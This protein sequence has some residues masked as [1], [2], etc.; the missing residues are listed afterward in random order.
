MT[1]T[2]LQ[3][4]NGI[5]AELAV[6][7]ISLAPIVELR[8]ALP[9]ALGVYKMPLLQAFPVVIIGNML[10]AFLIVYGWDWFIRQVGKY[11]PWLNRLLEKRYQRMQVQW[12]AK[13]EKYGP[14]ALILFVAIPLPGSG[15]W[16]GS[17][18]AWLFGI[19]KKKALWAI[20]AGALIS[21]IAV[22]VIT[23]GGLSL[24]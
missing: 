7:I 3:L 9:I 21:G 5:P 22:T 23:L 16:S 19:K 14:W 18:A 4:V 24:F 20:F 11:W 17:L 10:P 12:D 15:V 2:L 13:I 6:F 8:G 1:D